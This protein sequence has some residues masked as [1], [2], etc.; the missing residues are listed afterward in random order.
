MTRLTSA[1]EGRTRSV[2]PKLSR[3]PAAVTRAGTRQDRSLKP[4]PNTRPARFF[5]RFGTMAGGFTSV[6]S[7]DGCGRPHWPSVAS[8]CQLVSAALSRVAGAPVTFARR[9]AGRVAP[10]SRRG[11]G[12]DPRRGVRFQ[13]DGRWV[14]KV[15]LSASS[16]HDWF[17]V[18][19]DDRPDHAAAALSGHESEAIG[20]P[21]WCSMP[22]PPAATPCDPPLNTRR[23]Q[24]SAHCPG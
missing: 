1:G 24:H 10:P 14:G 4:R 11:W 19:P 20:A 23:D 22:S 3:G 7:A 6:S 5:V 12:D 21:R 8:C 17:L 16:L 18:V 15:S 2:R 9:P 13:L